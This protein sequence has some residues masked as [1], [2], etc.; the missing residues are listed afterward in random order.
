MQGSWQWG[1]PAG[2]PRFRWGRSR[3]RGTCVFTGSTVCTVVNPCKEWY[4]H[5]HCI[6]M[7][8]ELGHFISQWILPLILVQVTQLARM[9]VEEGSWHLWTPTLHHLLRDKHRFICRGEQN[10]LEMTKY[11]TD[12]CFWLII[13]WIV[14]AIPAVRII[15]PWMQW[16]RWW[17]KFEKGILTI[18]WA[19]QSEVIY[20]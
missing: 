9:I 13:L 16:R 17:C 20:S 1:K 2:G 19:K 10:L 6:V 14:F 3:A 18:A 11:I 4:A 5:C 7:L 15:L 8:S 12:R